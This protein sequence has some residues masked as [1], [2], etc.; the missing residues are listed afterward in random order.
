MKTS[1]R[2]FDIGG[3][4]IAGSYRYGPGLL[5]GTRWQFVHFHWKSRVLSGP[6][7]IGGSRPRTPA[8]PNRDGSLWKASGRWTN[9]KGSKD[10]A[11][12]TRALGSQGAGTWK[13]GP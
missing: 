12:H 10:A 8:R 3:K 11:G 1:A 7:L 4:V 6:A 2:S 9:G 5:V 13:E